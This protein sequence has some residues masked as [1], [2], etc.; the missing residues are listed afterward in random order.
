MDGWDYYI[1]F[2][3]NV[4]IARN[5]RYKIQISTKWMVGVT[6]LISVQMYILHE[7]QDT[8]FR[9]VYKMDGRGYY[10]DFFANVHIAQNAK[11]KIQISTKWMVGVTILISLQMYILQ[12]IQDTKYRSVQN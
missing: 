12:E 4:H 6:T 11:Y 8:K 7:I 9:S 3:T 1:D 10:I 5:T 2:C